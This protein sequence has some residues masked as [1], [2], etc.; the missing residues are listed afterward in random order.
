[1]PDDAILLRRY[2]ETGAEDAFAELVRRHID[3]VYSASLRRVGGDA[4]LAEDVVQHVFI[5][6]ARKADSV[7]R[8]PMLTS[9]L[10]TAARHEAANI[11]RSERR[12][13]AREQ[14]AHAMNTMPSALEPQPDWHRVA[15]VLD[16]A[17]DALGARDRAALLLRFVERQAF[18]DVGAALRITDDAARMRVNRALE[19]LRLELAKRGV[20]STGAGLAATLAGH[21]VGAAP[22]GLAT[23]VIGTALAA[24]PATS[25]LAGFLSILMATKITTGVGGAALLAV[26]VGTAIIEIKARR[27]AEGLRTTL[28]SATTRLDARL[29][30][31]QQ[32]TDAAK[33]ALDTT[34]A[35][36]ASAKAPAAPPPPAP[37]HDPVKAGNE[38]LAR[39]PE[40]QALWDEMRRATL[41]G[42]L[43]WRYAAL[44]LSPSEREQLETIQ[45]RA[46]SGRTTLNGPAGSVMLQRA[47]SLSSKEALEQTRTLLGSEKYR[48]LMELRRFDLGLD[49]T[50]EL[51]SALYRTDPLSA[52]Q[53][54]A[55]LETVTRAS[56]QARKASET[57]KVDL[58][59]TSLMA[60]AAAALT[61]GQQ[62]VIDRL[63]QRHEATAADR[64]RYTSA[65]NESR[66]QTKETVARAPR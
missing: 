38:L 42:M 41:A 20:V 19:K 55:I 29:R 4:H 35:E 52:E 22:A 1:M 60:S 16:Q 30:E 36:L 15:P 64:E 7:S 24:V 6:L 13:K 3:W 11:V 27:E 28:H 65:P 49:T 57:L 50:A 62:A 66:Q 2:A 40:A 43:L 44:G 21:S 34:R 46:M 5:A 31:L 25:P 17:I 33:Q 56:E 45:L 59:R 39:H 14:E 58:D 10:Y 32:Q 54:A 51:A 53:T 9:W 18:A 61:P 63:R 8:H 26:A 47:P 12:R 37:V 23:S 48:Q